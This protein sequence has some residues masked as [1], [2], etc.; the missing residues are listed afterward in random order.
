MELI[1][2]MDL[3][4]GRVVRLFQGDFGTET[5]YQF[6]PAELYAR[7]V[8]AG[9]HRLHLVDLDGA[10]D[11][12]AG[13]R[14]IVG[15]LAVLGRLRL[16]SGGGLR[17]QASVES[18]LAAGVERAVIGSIAVTDPAVVTDW[19][20]RFGHERLVLAFDIRLNTRGEPCVTT[21]GWTEQSELSLWEA[22]ATYLPQGVTHV[23]CTD[24]HRDGAMGG[25][26]IELYREA[27]ARFPA[28][29]WQASGGVRD[30]ADLHALDRTGVAA[31][32]SGKALIEGHIQPEELRPFLPGA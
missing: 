20:G 14:S 11:G 1:P 19:F 32:I 27:V 22:V 16:Q 7:Y 21:H 2:A 13:N 18:L 17:T 12:A 10:R 26:N 6:A 3:K 4:D 24:V 9:A 5:R 25:P 23:L 29:R 30:A 31:A 15:S 28:I 8:A